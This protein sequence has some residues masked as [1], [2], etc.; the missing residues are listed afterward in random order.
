MYSRLVYGI[1]VYC[2]LALHGFTS[3][4]C[5]LCSQ[6]KGTHSS[7]VPMLLTLFSLLL[8][9]LSNVGQALV[10]GV[11]GLWVEVPISDI[12]HVLGVLH[13]MPH[14]EEGVCLA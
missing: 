6:I 14:V 4:I 5:L 3:E 2:M 9:Q 11:L 12:D 8:Q 10:E 7:H 13:S 1:S